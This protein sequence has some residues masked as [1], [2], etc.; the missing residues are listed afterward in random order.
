MLIRKHEKEDEKGWVRCRILSFLDTAYFDNVLKEKEIYKNPA[1]E[2]VAV[3]ER[4]VVG[5]I[6]VEYEREKKTVCTDAEG[7][8]GMIWHIAVHPDFQ[9]RGIGQ[10]LL[11]E[12]EKQAKEI[13][14]HYLEA[15]T[16]DDKWVNAWYVKNSFV[17]RSSYLQ[18][19]ME[20]D[21]LSH[22]KSDIPDLHSVQAWAHYT[23]KD[24]EK[25]KSQFER[26]HEC[27]CYTKVL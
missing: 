26:V 3:I 14:L 16:R 11:L 7:L 20:E 4:Q 22:L 15:W 6:D 2:L 25:I 9:R 12:A 10:K 13:G 8:G 5:L 21:E 1:I 27:F 23:G 19:L 17:N 18:V 24:K